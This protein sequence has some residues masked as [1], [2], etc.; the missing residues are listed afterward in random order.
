MGETLIG[1]IVVGAICYLAGRWVGRTS[2]LLQITKGL[3]ENRKDIQ[4]VLDQ[5]EQDLKD[6]QKLADVVSS[7]EPLKVE[8]V[9][10]QIFLYTEENDEFISQGSSLQEALDKAK[11]RFPS[12]SFKGHLTKAEAEALGVTAK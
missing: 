12:R 8:R 11:T 3:I 7:A 9:G 4:R 6:E 1:Y 5:F 10:E 2:A